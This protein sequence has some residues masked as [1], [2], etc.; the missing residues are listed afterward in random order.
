MHVNN[1]KFHY[2]NDAVTRSTRFSQGTRLDS[3]T[4]IANMLAKE[5]YSAQY[6]YAQSTGG[7]RCLFVCMYCTLSYRGVYRM[8]IVLNM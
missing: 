1:K 7:R 5:D 2:T 3:Y 6:A 8:K 4:F